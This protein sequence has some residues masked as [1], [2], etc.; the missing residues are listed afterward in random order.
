MHGVARS[1]VFLLGE[2]MRLCAVWVGAFLLIDIACSVL[3]RVVSGLAFTQTAALLK[4]VVVLLLLILL[5]TEG[6]HISSDGLSRIVAPWGWTI[7]S[8]PPAAVSRDV[9]GRERSD[10][11]I[12]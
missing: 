10:G 9:P 3:S 4:M 6:A 1:G 2:G 7:E 12:T 5:V 8:V 11:G